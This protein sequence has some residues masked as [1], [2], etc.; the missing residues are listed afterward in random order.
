MISLIFGGLDPYAIGTVEPK[1]LCRF[2]S[3]Q[4]YKNIKNFTKTRALTI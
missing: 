3:E 1:I 2:L 4:E